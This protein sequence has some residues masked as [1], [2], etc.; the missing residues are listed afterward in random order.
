[1][2]QL[3]FYLLNYI[4]VQQKHNA[5]DLE[6]RHKW[7][8]GTFRLETLQVNMASETQTCKFAEYKH[9]YLI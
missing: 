9:R 2:A 5:V 1:M 7:L 3:K 6:N 4:R 8:F